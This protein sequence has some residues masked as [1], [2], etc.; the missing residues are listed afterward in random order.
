MVGKKQR[1]I[2]SLLEEEEEPTEDEWNLEAWWVPVEESLLFDLSL[3]LHEL[4]ALATPE[5]QARAT[6]GVVQGDQEIE[7]LEKELEEKM[8][9]KF[10][11]QDRLDA[12]QREWNEIP[13]AL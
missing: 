11:L 5:L 13:L 8:Q 3:P 6:Q 1:P 2:P 12:L 4:L 10:A 9:E 7:Q